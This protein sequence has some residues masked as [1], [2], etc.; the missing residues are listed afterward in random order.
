MLRDVPHKSLAGNPHLTTC[1]ALQEQPFQK[2]VMLW[3][4]L[5]L[6][7]PPAE[8]FIKYNANSFFFFNFP[9]F[10][11]RSCFLHFFSFPFH[12]FLFQFTLF[13]F[14]VFLFF[15]LSFFLSSLNSIFLQ[16]FLNFS[17]LICS[18][19]A[20]HPPRKSPTTPLQLPVHFG[21]LRNI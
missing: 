9:L 14:L 3:C 7:F 5:V 4:S 2:L 17:S 1:V 15:Y 20:S 13:P 19:W 16:F 21:F 11:F 12:C 6:S 8:F 18:G 10:Y